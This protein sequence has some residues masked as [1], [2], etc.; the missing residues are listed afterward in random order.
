MRGIAPRAT[1]VRQASWHWDLAAGRIGLAVLLLAAWKVSADAAGPLYFA[2]PV[3]V[4][5][6]IVE[7][8]MSGTMTHHVFVTVRLAA[9]GFAAGCGAGVALPLLLYPLPR[10]T[11]ALEPYIVASA[12][13]PKY[14]VVPLLILWLGIDDAPKLW[15]VGL[16]VFYPVFIAVLAGIRNVDH[17]L[18]NMVRVLGASDAPAMRLVA[19]RSMLPFL[20]ASL[21]IAVPRAVSAAIIGEL[22]VGNEGIGYVI[23]SSRQS[24]DTIGVFAGVVIATG[25]VVAVTAVMRRIERQTLGWLPAERELSI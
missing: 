3:A 15:L 1:A 11:T 23:E 21:R 9:L 18:V 19:W 16:L 2:D 20:F 24:F 6:R 8:T 14:A 7:S 5:E 4:F 25:L 10:L 17:R 12:G 22:L 13:I